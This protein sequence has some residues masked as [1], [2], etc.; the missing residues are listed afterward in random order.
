M[1]YRRNPHL[2]KSSTKLNQF[3]FELK[4]ILGG[5]SLEQQPNL[6]LDDLERIDE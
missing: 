1:L 2:T 5:Y 6:L 3:L 4:E